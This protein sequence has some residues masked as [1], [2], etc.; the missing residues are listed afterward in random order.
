MIYQPYLINIHRTP[1]PKCRK[2]IS[3][4][5]RGTLTMTDN[6]AGHNIIPYAFFKKW[7][8]Q[9]MYSDERELNEK[10]NAK[11]SRYFK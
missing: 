7:C 11:I 6:R 4:S 5:I 3:L 8:F 9:N 10:C 2:H 1:H